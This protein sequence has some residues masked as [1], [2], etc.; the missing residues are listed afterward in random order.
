MTRA[1]SSPTATRPRSRSSASR[2][3][4]CAAAR[5]EDVL[6]A[7]VDADDRP[8][9][10]GRLL[11]DE[12]LTT[13]DPAGPAHGA[14]DA[15]GRH[16]GLG[17]DQLGARPRRRRP[18]GGRRL[19]DERHHAVPRGRAAPGGQRAGDARAGR[20][21]G[22]P[23]PHRHARR[24]RGPAQLGVRA[25]D[26]GGRPPARSVPSA[27]VLR[28]ENDGSATVVGSWR[29]A[30]LDRPAAGLL[31]STSTETRS[32]PASTAAAVP[33]ASTTTTTRRARSP[34]GCARLGYRVVGGRAG[35]RRRPALGRA[36]RLD[37]G[38]RAPGSGLRAA[39]AA[40]SPSSS[41]RPCPTP[42]PTTSSRAPARASWRPATPSAGGWSATSTTAPSSGSCR[43]RC[44][45]ASS[46][47][48]LRDQSRP[49][50]RRTW[51]TAREQLKHALEELREL[52][53]GIHPA[54]LTD[55]GLAPALSA[56]A[57]RAPLPVEIDDVPD[58]RLPEPVE[59]AAYYL[60][61]EAITNVAKHAH[62]SHVSVERAA[63]QRPRARP[64]RRRWRRRRRPRRR[65]GPARSR[66]PRRGA[67]RAPSRRQP[68]RRWHSPGGAYPGRM[69]ATA[70]WGQAWRSR[71]PRSRSRR[72]RPTTLGRGSS[73]AGRSL[74]PGPGFSTIASTGW[75]PLA[76]LFTAP[77][78][79]AGSAAPSLWLVVVRFAGL[80]AL[81][82]AFRLG[83]RAGG[84]IA[85]AIA[86]VALLATTEWLRYMS[87]GNVEPLVVA[88]MLGAIEQ[89][90]DGRRDAAFVLGALAGL[91]RP[92]VWPLVGA[93][94]PYVA[95][96]DRRWWPLAL[97]VPAMFALWI[98]P[99]WLGSGDLLHT[100]H[101]ARISAEP[102]NLQE[103]GDP[104]LEL[105]RGHGPDR[106]GA[107]VDRRA[108]RPGLRL[109][110]PRSHRGR[111][112]LRSRLR[113]RGPRSW[114]P[115]S[116]IQRCRATSSCPWPS[117]VSWPGSA[118]SRWC[119]WR[120]APAA[121]LCW[122]R[123]WSPRCVP[124]AGLPRRRAVPTRRPRRRPAPRRSRRSGAPSTAPSGEPRS[125]ACTRIVQPGGLENGLAWKLD[126]H[127]NA[128]GRWFSPAVGIAFIDRRRR[129]PSSR[130][131]GAA[132]P[133]RCDSRPR[134]RGVSFASG[135]A[136]QPR[137][138]GAP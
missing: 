52:A 48:E 107:G 132:T 27:S 8:V 61:A 68:T 95:V 88:L 135:G 84:P 124:F 64:R 15:T 36:G 97:G 89:H 66:R 129:R 116:A 120:P 13:G 35:L 5:P 77:L 28:Y 57:H 138:S 113:G 86:A 118:S 121:A 80:A 20:R 136:R 106:S 44:S 112:R 47:R 59:A 103:T 76:V 58:E 90:L 82:L 3:I 83:A 71:R 111:T 125:R 17:L 38:V 30:G 1:G 65:L 137:R 110:H 22:R 69:R 18:P 109:A 40:T 104:A 14:P 23:A 34:S 53:R 12:A 72:L 126:L 117:A 85:G 32:S 63:R 62:A 67:P 70:W 87:A 115:L 24:Q 105:L 60:I 119:A 93:Y 56:L 10:G 42:T 108:V 99:D 96:T 54:I 134:A 9:A 4:D 39:P 21:A 19:D 131:C 75:K 7:A 133:P 43:S 130:D 2:A 102:V 94:A 45:C 46:R 55:G 123:P 16:A 98:V 11:G 33:S 41:R 37:H 127:L 114:R 79:L 92:E 29:E 73:S 74:V 122:R 128:V 31:G 78:A 100:F 50:P 101:L 91:A 6:G 51:P 81:A 49:R 26:R 25:G